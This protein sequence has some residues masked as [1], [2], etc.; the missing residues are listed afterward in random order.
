MKYL[1]YLLCL[2]S[3][4]AQAQTSSYPSTP[5][6]SSS[7]PLRKIFIHHAHAF[8]HQVVQEQSIRGATLYSIKITPVPD[9][10]LLEDYQT[11][12]LRVGYTVS[13]D[14]L[15]NFT[16]DNY[17]RV[18]TRIRYKEKDSLTSIYHYLGN[19]T[20]LQ[21][22]IETHS[23]NKLLD[24]ARNKET[25][26]TYQDQT[27]SLTQLEEIYN[28]ATRGKEFL[29]ER[30]IP[31]QQ[32]IS[33]TFLFDSINPYQ[34]KQSVSKETHKTLVEELPRQFSKKANR[35]VYIYN[36]ELEDYDIE[37]FCNNQGS[38]LHHIETSDSSWTETRYACSDYNFTKD[39][40]RRKYKKTIFL[41]EQ[42]RPQKIV[43][44]GDH[45]Y[46]SSFIVDFM[47]NEKNLLTTIAIYN[48]VV[49]QKLYKIHYKTELE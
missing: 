39:L 17:G 36:N 3:C 23:N 37:A 16:F 21:K 2:S 27:K 6:L 32:I 28:Y 40:S 42:Q 29:V 34:L 13:N 43:V 35:S 31:R 46:K 15:F 8:P 1:I 41:D 19:T 44:N 20:K 30:E 25:Y 48:N 24:K 5:Y 33:Q 26:Y 9:T 22:S 10:F 47:Y 4:I 49:K 14:T 18:K 12:T 45:K 11:P 7:F 38:I